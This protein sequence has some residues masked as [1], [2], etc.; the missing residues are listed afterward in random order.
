MEFINPLPY[1]LKE[2]RLRSKLSQK[3]LGIKIG[4]DPS[5]ASGRMNHYE[6][7][8]HTPDLQTLKRIA[9]ELDVPLN[10]FFCETE[11]MANFVVMLH[12]L[13]K[14]KRDKILAIM[15]EEIDSKV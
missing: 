9:E 6:K 12:Q 4:L 8:R 5:S 13:P 11:E 3:S 10:Y 2:A 15:S 14:E 1:R 7:G